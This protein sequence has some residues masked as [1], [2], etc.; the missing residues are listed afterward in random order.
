MAVLC[1]S[2]EIKLIFLKLHP[3]IP[4]YLVVFLL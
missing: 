4:L 2:Y 3:L 1:L